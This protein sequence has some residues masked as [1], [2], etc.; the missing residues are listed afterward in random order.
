MCHDVHHA[1]ADLEAKGVEF[2]T[3]ITD[4]GYGL[5]TRFKGPGRR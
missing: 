1:V 2:T 4:E 3:P 5:V